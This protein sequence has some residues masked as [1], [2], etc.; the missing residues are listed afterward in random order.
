MIGASIET[1]A[2]V[3][4]SNF[5]TGADNERTREQNAATI[6]NPRVAIETA[7]LIGRGEPAKADRKGAKIDK[8][9]R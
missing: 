8:R 3:V 9:R 7:R 1:A 5:A 4:T 2:P 6:P